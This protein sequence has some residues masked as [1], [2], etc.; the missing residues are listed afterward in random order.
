MCQSS[1]V[2]SRQ[3]YTHS[4]ESKHHFDSPYISSTIKP[5][6]LCPTRSYCASLN[7]ACSM[8][9]PV[10][11][12]MRP[13]SNTLQMK[14]MKIEQE[15][16]DVE[17][18]PTTEP[19][20]ISVEDL[21]NYYANHKPIGRKYPA[22]PQLDF[23]SLYIDSSRDE[24]SDSE[25]EAGESKDAAKLATKS[26]V[27]LMREAR[28][29]V[30]SKVDLISQVV[31]SKPPK[32]TSKMKQEESSGDEEESSEEDEE[33]KDPQVKTSNEERYKSCDT[34][35]WARVKCV[36]GKKSNKHG[37]KICLQCEK[38]GRQC[39]FSIRGQRPVKP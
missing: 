27:K 16:S 12:I 19:K 31:T 18:R 37:D 13:I 22:Q 32:E 7:F 38:H 36:P 2:A 9:R 24:V 33:M 39:H 17:Q 6:V 15:P 25:S 29:K 11:I 21:P 35:T 8:A 10:K 5:H 4:R 23:E 34:C 28:A 26:A 20:W 1:C 30:E 3:S 14:E